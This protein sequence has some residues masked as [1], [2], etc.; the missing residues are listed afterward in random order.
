M[1]MNKKGI[2]TPKQITTQLANEWEIINV[3]GDKKVSKQQ[4][5]KI[6]KQTITTLGKNGGKDKFVAKKFNS[7]LSE[8]FQGQD[9]FERKQSI[10][11]VTQ[12]LSKEAEAPKQRKDSGKENVDGNRSNGNANRASAKGKDVKAK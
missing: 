5:E 12:M 8:Q 11:I 7:I 9:E 1:D 10:K 6:C 3:N 2:Y 4:L